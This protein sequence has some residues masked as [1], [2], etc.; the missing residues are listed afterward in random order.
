MTIIEYIDIILH[1]IK[2]GENHPGVKYALDRGF[3]YIKEIYDYLYIAR[4]KIITNP[5]QLSGD[6]GYMNLLGKMMM[7]DLIFCDTQ[8]GRMIL[9]LRDLLE[10]LVAVEST[11]ELVSSEDRDNNEIVDI[12]RLFEQEIID[13]ILA[14][15]ETY[16]ALLDQL[17]EI[18]MKY[19]QLQF[20][21]LKWNISVIMS[22]IQEIPN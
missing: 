16:F 6:K 18:Q 19:H 14:D 9:W 20:G 22:P 13:D 8:F 11:M 4:N 21:D 2:Q 5:K 10:M 1:A 17:S 3:P 15:K 7:D 12:M